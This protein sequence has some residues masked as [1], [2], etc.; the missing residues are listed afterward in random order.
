MADQN[1]EQKPVFHPAPTNVTEIKES[2]LPAGS[3]M[4]VNGVH[5][6]HPH[7]EVNLP[8]VP[9][10]RIGDTDAVTERIVHNHEDGTVTVTSEPLADEVKPKVVTTQGKGRAAKGADAELQ[11]VPEVDLTKTQVDGSEPQ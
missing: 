11:N 10:P 3:T 7:A 2:R 9:D 4:V 8:G 6:P 5:V 1:N